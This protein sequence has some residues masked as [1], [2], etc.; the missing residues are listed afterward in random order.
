MKPYITWFLVI[1]GAIIVGGVFVMT[2]NR[3]WRNE[4]RRR[5]RAQRLKER[6]LEKERVRLAES[7]RPQI[8]FNG[9][10]ATA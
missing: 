1:V 5:A 4:D 10:S 6:E 2:I 9:K 8:G 3:Y 7:L